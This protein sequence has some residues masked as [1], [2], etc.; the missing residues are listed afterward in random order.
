MVI[1]DLY[2][3]D[4]VLVKAVA[5]MD[6]FLVLE[7]TCLAHNGGIHKEHIFYACRQ[8]ICRMPEKTRQHFMQKFL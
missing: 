7:D 3:Y 1:G 8:M 4:P 5:Q 6:P 2:L